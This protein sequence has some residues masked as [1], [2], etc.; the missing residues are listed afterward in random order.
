MIWRAH[1]SED[2]AESI[3]H[4]TRNRSN[5]N[6]PVTGSF[7]TYSAP[8][9]RSPGLVVHPPADVLSLATGSK[10][11]KGSGRGSEDRNGLAN[12]A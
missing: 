1:D 9:P 4:G 8:D 3:A 10:P 12:V 2:T 11:A 7:K 5:A 6:Q